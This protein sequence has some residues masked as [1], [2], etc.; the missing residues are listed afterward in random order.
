[1]NLQDRIAA[2]R[3]RITRAC[4][5]SGR[6]PASIELLPVSKKQ[7]LEA[8]AEAA[9]FGFNRFGE[10]YVQEGAA[11]AE[12]RPDLAFLLIGPLQRNKAKLALQRF[13]EI[14]TLD[15]MDLA[16]RVVEPSGT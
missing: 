5:G 12:S 1:M 15:R 6:D 13:A 16:L 10:N 9:S 2:L 4:E 7:S 8:I 14:Q 3:T 11:K